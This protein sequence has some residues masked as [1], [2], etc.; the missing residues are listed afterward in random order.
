VRAACRSDQGARG[1][2]DLGPYHRFRVIQ[3]A[4]GIVFQDTAS[5]L[6]GV[7]GLQVTDVQA[8]PGGTLEV[9]AVTGHPAAAACPGRSGS[10]SALPIAP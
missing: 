3:K 9:W 5:V 6:F 2:Y 4:A 7:E 8:L 10:G 1:F